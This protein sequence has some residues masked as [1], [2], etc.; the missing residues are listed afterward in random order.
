M[1]VTTQERPGVYSSYDASTVVSGQAGAKTVGLVA[2]CEDCDGYGEAQYLTS[3]EEA[4]N[5]FGSDASISELV[6]LIL[7]NGAASVVAVAVEDDEDYEDAFAVFEKLDG[8]GLMCCDSTDLTVHQDLRDSVETVSQSRKE[9][10]A[11]VAAGSGKTVAN[12]VTHA[13]GLNSERMVLVAPAVEGGTVEVAAAVAGA[14]AGATDP[15]VPLGGAV[16]LGLDSLELSYSDSEIDLLVRGGITAV[17]EI[18]GETSVIRG[19]TT[20]TTT[21]GVSD[22]TWR[23]LT[24]ILIVDDV[25]PTLRSSL[26]SKFQ[27]SKN[28]EQSR[29]AIRTQAILELEQK[30]SNEIITSYDNVTVTALEDDPTVCMVEFSFAVAHGLNQIWLVAHVTV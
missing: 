27:R 8:I 1:T 24:S 19:I 14:I 15:A 20:Y 3:H 25:I 26:R 29:G 13:A 16:L 23:E 11:V 17:E 21:G 22:T 4:C 6:R 30:L 7:L 5:L 9:R 28:T 2:I 12:L 18:S 10:I